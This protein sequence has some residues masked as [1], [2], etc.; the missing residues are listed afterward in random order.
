M[1]KYFGI[2]FIF[3]LLVSAAVSPRV[4]KAEELSN[5]FCQDY[6]NLPSITW[7]GKEL[8]RWQLGMLTVLKKTSLYKLTGSKK[9]ITRT[10]K[11]GETFRIYSFLPGKL[12]LGSGYYIDRDARVKYE[13]PSKTKLLAVQCQYAPYGPKR[14]TTDV[15]TLSF[16]PDDAA[17]DETRPIVYSIRSTDHTLHA[18]NTATKEEK[19]LTLSGKP[20]KMYV[21][22]NKIYVTIVNKAHDPYWWL[23]DQTGAIDIIDALSFKKIKSLQI[24]FDPYDIVVDKHD[25]IY[26]SGGSGQNPGLLCMNTKTGEQFLQWYMREKTKIALSA[27]ETM[28]YAYDMS[29][30]IPRR[31]SRYPIHDGKADVALFEKTEMPWRKV[32]SFI[33][34][35]PDGKYVFDNTGQ[36]FDR[37][38]HFVDELQSP[39]SSWP[40][41][42]MAFDLPH[43]RFYVTWGGVL[44]E[45][46]YT[47]FTITKT[48]Y[49]YNVPKKMWIQ[50]GKLYILTVDSKRKGHIETLAI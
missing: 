20:E 41:A 28:L 18:V 23:A 38:F 25:V 13:T 1:K 37:D 47:T 5:A 30:V 27:D 50:N 11:P 12:G 35:S 19:V 8:K 39:L 10:L 7:K 31:F 21:R 15:K 33:E 24:K 17:F 14:D 34:V 49:M 2:I 40:F 43:N 26:V 29:N 6:A 16:N 48:Q 46:N 3:M 42:A 36:Y 4:V 22:N 44:Y 45:Y 9:T 32:L